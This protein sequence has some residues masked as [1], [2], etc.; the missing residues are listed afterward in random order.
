[1][2]SLPNDPFSSLLDQAQPIRVVATKALESS[3][4][5]ASVREPGVQSAEKTYGLL[6]HMSTALGVN[7][8][9][10]HNS[11]AFSDWSQSTPQRVTAWHGIRMV[12]DLNLSYLDPL[13]ATWPANR[14]GAQGDGPKAYCT[15]CHQGLAKPLN[16]A[17][18][19]KDN[20]ELDAAT[21]N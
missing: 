16:G 18:M 12:R 4:I 14:L 8:T 19:H 11:R 2:S 1:M 3:S 10:C 6:I 15:T 21:L 20:L 5:D 13:K 9:Y 7:C 17:Q